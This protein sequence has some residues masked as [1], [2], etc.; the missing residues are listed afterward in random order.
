MPWFIL[1]ESVDS[2]PIDGGNKR[3]ALC[4]PDLE[5]ALFSV[6]AQGVKATLEDVKPASGLAAFRYAQGIGTFD[7]PYVPAIE[8]ANAL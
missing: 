7:E 6:T 5:R 3:R 4:A 8:A 2:S 1:R